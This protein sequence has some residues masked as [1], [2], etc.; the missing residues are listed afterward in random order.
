MNGRCGACGAETRLTASSLVSYMG[1]IMSAQTR[2]CI[3]C[4]SVHVLVIDPPRDDRAF[5]KP[6][7]ICSIVEENGGKEVFCPACGLSMFFVQHID[8]V[9]HDAS[10]TAE[11]WVCEC[12]MGLQ[13]VTEDRLW[14]SLRDPGISARLLLKQ[15]RGAV[16]CSPSVLNQ[17]RPPRRAHSSLGASPAPA[18]RGRRRSTPSGR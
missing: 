14:T 8:V 7:A 2:E 6:E 5:R 4:H 1:L 11:S 18:S 10:K 13:V 3:E 15:A 17:R 16:H 9:V 12:G